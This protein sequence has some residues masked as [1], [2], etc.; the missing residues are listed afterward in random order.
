MSAQTEEW[1]EGLA[2][3][4]VKEFQS[5]CE[6]A[7]AMSL[8]EERIA[9]SVVKM[10]DNEDS[11]KMFKRLKSVEVRFNTPNHKIKEED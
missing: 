1:S 5:K 10:K 3:I 7:D 6:P 9:L 8:V 2:S 11:K 4:V